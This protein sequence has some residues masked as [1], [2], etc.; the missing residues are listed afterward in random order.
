MIGLVYLGPKQIAFQETPLP[1][2]GRRDVLVRVKA[3]AICGSDVHGYLG[4]TGRRTPPMIM[5]HEFAGVVEALGSDVSEFQLG[6]RVLGIPSSGCGQ[7]EFC[8]IGR[9][10]MCAQRKVLGVGSVNGAMADFVAVPAVSLVR[11]P[12]AVSDIQA[13]MVE[14]LTVAYHA[15]RRR[16]IQIMEDVALVGAGTIGLLLLQIMRQAGPRRI[17]VSDIL[18]DK[19]ERARRYG[20]T[21]TVNPTRT[22][23]AAYIVG[24]TAGRGVDLAFEAVGFEETVQTAMAAT[25]LGGD[26]VVVGNVTKMGQIHT[27]GLVTREQRLIGTYGGTQEFA[28]ALDLIA[29]GRVDLSPFT[30]EVWPFRRGAE[31]FQRLAAE[32]AGL[33]KVILQMG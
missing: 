6:E 18:E 22:D 8:R 14:P 32:E 1:T 30:G 17:F 21:H 12:P 26:V 29:A 25:R 11:I 33:S 4:I 5:G 13:T 24:E 2:L 16:P 28:P 3:C 10:E 31:A 7:C 9:P 23:A 19:L 15:F 27:Q 20:A